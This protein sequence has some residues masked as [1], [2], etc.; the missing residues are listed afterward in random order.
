MLSTILKKQRLILTHKNPIYTL[1]IS[2]ETQ[3]QRGNVTRLVNFLFNL[4]TRQQRT[5]LIE[6]CSSG[7]AKSHG[8][9][10]AGVSDNLGEEGC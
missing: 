1:I 6:T 9:N 10:H 7:Q 2:Y 8:I 5:S 4:G 3:E